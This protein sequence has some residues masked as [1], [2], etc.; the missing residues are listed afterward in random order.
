SRTLL[1][2]ILVLAS[3]TFAVGVLRGRSAEEMFDGAVALAVGAIPEEL[4]A[5]V[6]I[7]LAIGVN[8]MARRRAII[9]RLPAVEAL[10]STTVICSDKTGTLTQNRM[11][12]QHLYGGVSFW[13]LKSCGLPMARSATWPCRK[14]C[15]LDCSATTPAQQP[16]RAGG[17]SH[18]DRA[19]GGGPFGGHR[20]PGGPRAP[21]APGCDPV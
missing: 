7:T 19:A 16:G 2:A 15:W 3:L 5:I 20:S 12:V 4:P 13:R 18:R 10:G 14:R 17:R 11:T 1:K 6:T 9:R 21:P 8:R